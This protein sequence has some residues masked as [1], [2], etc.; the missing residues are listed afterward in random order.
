[1]IKIGKHITITIDGKP[2]TSIKAPESIDEFDGH[3][4]ACGSNQYSE[5][6]T[7]VQH[8]FMTDECV[9]IMTCAKCFENFHYW[10]EVEAPES[11]EVI[12][13]LFEPPLG[14]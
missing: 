8:G 6:F 14:G 5:L 3:C 13:I 11:C 4:S 9:T 10:Y 7:I 1:M 2:Y 12:A